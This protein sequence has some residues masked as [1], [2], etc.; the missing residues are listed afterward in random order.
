M[1]QPRLVVVVAALAAL[2][3]VAGGAR[4]AEPEAIQ[5]GYR[6][7]LSLLAAGER[8]AALEQLVALETAATPR[9]E[10]SEVERL[11]RAKYHLIRELLPGQNEILVPILLLHH[12]AFIRYR[13]QRHRVLSQHS[14][15]FVSELA[16]YYA[17][18]AESQGARVVAARVLASLAG[19]Q[20]ESSLTPMALELFERALALDPGHPA[21]LLGRAAL[22]EKTGHPDLAI[23][24]LRKLLAA[25]PRHSEGR[26]RLALCL[27]RTGE[28][29][30]AERLL[31]EL[32]AESEPR[33]VVVLALEELVRSHLE[34]ERLPAALD[35]A[36]RA[37]ERFPQSQRLRLLVSYLLDRSRDPGG[38]LVAAEQAVALEEKQDTPRLLYN[39]WPRNE[40]VADRM[41]LIE[42]AQP[43]LRLLADALRAT[44]GATGS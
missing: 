18:K 9:G 27:A 36:R 2:G 19:F 5:S 21:A 17:K 10:D 20:Q 26:L 40:L 34:A 22:L 16:D 38:A 37:A 11:W 14:R 15:V 28:R 25:D 6:Q 33:W 41:A 35:L 44:A 12:D 8:E 32:A 31:A 3:G 30:D 43:R 1:R 39:D 24:P 4:A 7:V 42:S 23:E 29:R 13:E